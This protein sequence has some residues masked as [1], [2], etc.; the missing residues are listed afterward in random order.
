MRRVLILISIVAVCLARVAVCQATSGSLGLFYD[1]D[2]QSACE[3]SQPGGPKTLY[4]ILLNPT[5][6]S[7]HGW[8]AAV[9]FV[10][11][12]IYVID[13]DV[14]GGGV[15]SGVAHEFRVALD[16]PMAT[17][18]V[19]VLGTVTILPLA[20]ESC[21][22]LTGVSSPSLPELGPL[23]WPVADSPEAIGT[24]DYLE[25]GVDAI[26]GQCVFIPENPYWP[27][28][29]VVSQTMRNWGTL[30]SFYR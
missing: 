17:S 15:N 7:L 2:A 13:S 11:Q 27:C 10:E 24:F 16:E 23:V 4:I 28:V 19:T 1:E 29:D 3:F 20:I 5:F 14:Y 25:N 22:I 30:K 6:E 12:Q 8:E 18:P 26:V 9:Q 21:L